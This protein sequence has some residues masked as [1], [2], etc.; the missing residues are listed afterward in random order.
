MENFGIII[1]KAREEKGWL[2]RQASAKLDIDQSLIS[3]F[4]NGDRRPTRMQV[5]KLSD[6]YELD[7]NM[8]IISWMSEKIVYEI[9]NEENASVILKVA[10]EKI[11]FNKL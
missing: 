8:L 1:K 9:S 3:K 11:K 7:L 5:E 4:E 6:V 2:I 10:E